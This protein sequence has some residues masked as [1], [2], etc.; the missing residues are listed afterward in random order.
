MRC[1]KRFELA[2]IYLIPQR[3]V[4]Q[5]RV[6]QF[7]R[8]WVP[9]SATSSRRRMESDQV[10]ALMWNKLSSAGLIGRKL[11]V[12]KT[13][14]ADDIAAQLCRDLGVIVE[15]SHVDLVSDWI[16]EA[17]RLEPMQKRLRGDFSQDPLHDSFL[18]EHSR[19]QQFASSSSFLAVVHSVE[20]VSARPSRRRLRGEGDEG[21]RAQRENEQKEFWSQEL[22]KELCKM[23]APA[24]EELEHCVERRH[25]HLALAGRTRY[26]TLKRYVKVWR[27]FMQWVAASKG[28]G[29]YPEIGD[30]VEFLFT[31]YEEPCGPTVPPLVVKAVTWMERTA[32]IDPRRRLWES[33]VVASVRDYIVEMLSKDKPPTKRAPRYPII[34]M[35]SFEHMVE[36][37]K[38]RLG[39]RVVAWIKLVKLWA[40]LRWDDIQRINPKELKYYG[41][42]MTT[43]LRIT[44]TT[45]PSKRVQELP[46]CV[47]EHA[48]IS[49]PFWLKTGFDLIK[50]HASFDRDYLL[51]KLNEN[52]SG[53]RRIMALYGDIS[54]YSAQVR[55]KAVRPGTEV[56]LIH[57]VISAFWTEHSERATLPTGLALLQAPREERDMLGRWKPDGSD[58]YV[59]MYNGVISRLQQKF[60]A[61]AKKPERTKILDERDIME[62]VISWL[63]ERCEGLDSDQTDR[64]VQHLEDSLSSPMLPGWD[65]VAEEGEQHVPGDQA[66]TAEPAEV[67]RE[68]ESA[69]IPTLD[70]PRKPMFIVVNNGNRCKRLHKS[71]GGCWMGREMSFKSSA[72]FFT[73][74]DPAEYTHYCKVCWPKAGPVAVDTDSDSSS[75]TSSSKS[76]RETSS[77]ESGHD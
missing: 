16:S 13:N 76:S 9:A 43:I 74:P 18:H 48:F 75:S 42:R 45:G 62:S 38:R 52:W 58:T 28:S 35:E 46:V 14:D 36:D 5:I 8:C 66:Q 54:A 71:L 11:A 53:F 3:L 32:C 2:I 64:V 10:G 21:A 47:S 26:N 31:R 1:I 37:E 65:T 4:D 69:A 41:G 49:S 24:L 68:Q 23:E 67:G 34:Y 12:F 20:D 50:Q 56:A 6:E 17:Q 44:K 33:Q 72:E 55:R 19:S 15:Q 51:P 40:S 29:I 77:Q 30:L 60:A 61:A 27:S 59:R 73:L 39:Y 63:A 25:L 70:E 7:F 57:P 22:Y